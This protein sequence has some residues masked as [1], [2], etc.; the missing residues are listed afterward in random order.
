MSESLRARRPRI[1]PE[2]TAIR[3][4]MPRDSFMVEHQ[5]L[6]GPVC[7]S[8][9]Y[10]A[11]RI[12]HDSKTDLNGTKIMAVWDGGYSDGALISASSGRIWL[13]A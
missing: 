2:R 5:E 12:L 8:C 1:S 7:E 9:A 4:R 10:A 3:S 11:F 6:R 13:S